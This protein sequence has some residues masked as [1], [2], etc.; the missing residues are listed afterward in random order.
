MSGLPR[1]G[2]WLRRLV[3][4]VVAFVV[5]E[6]VLVL[7]D[8][9]PDAVRLAVLV[10]VCAAVLGL[11]LDALSEPGPAWDIEIDRP[12]IRDSGDPRLS[13]YVSLLS[14]HQA[15]RTPDAAVRDRFRL[16]ADRVL[17]QR[18]GTTRADPRAAE[19]LG[20]D[21]SALLDGPPRRLGPLDI[22]RCLSRIE[23]L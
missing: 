9:D 6:V 17:A 20:P 8:A 22:D 5:L 21:V 18:H 2:R 10:A 11:V 1:R 19:L 3:G 7:A 14:A 4:S 12:S 23:E 16:L 13:R 15:A